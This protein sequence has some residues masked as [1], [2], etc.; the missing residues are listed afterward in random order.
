[1]KEPIHWMFGLFIIWLIICA[2]RGW[3]AGNNRSVLIS[4]LKGFMYLFLVPVSINCI[5]DKK[6]IKTITDVVLVGTFLQVVLV[7]II[8]VLCSSDISNFRRMH[9]YIIDISLGTVTDVSD[10][11]FR[12]F[13]YSSPY[14]IVAC[15]IVVVR[16][17]QEKKMKLSYAILTA[18]YLNTLLLTFTRSL[19]LSAGITAIAAVVLAI[20]LYQKQI[21]VLLKYLA[22]TVL[23]TVIVVAGEEIVFEA[24]Y[25]NFAV[26]RV[27]NTELQFSYTSTLLSRI[28]GDEEVEEAVSEEEIQEQEIAEQAE[29]TAEETQVQENP[30]ELKSEEENQ[31]EYLMQTVDSDELRAVTESEL[32][33]LIQAH[34]IVGNGLGASAPSREGPDEYFYLDILARMGIIGVV[35]YSAPYIYMVLMTRKNKKVVMVVCAMLPFWIATAF[36][37]WMNAAIGITWYAVCVA[38]VRVMSADEVLKSDKC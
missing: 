16:Q 9:N 18:F 29:T 4:D 33:E 5:T 10:S 37:Q 1:M 24:N 12:I 14:L 2:V 35:L 3:Y 15:V 31:K 20:V 13:M 32:K 17:V 19:Y 23:C 8:N 38:I 30:E 34:P 27:F 21:K 11:V 26:A 36:N 28:R 6:R 22:V 25:F 7:F